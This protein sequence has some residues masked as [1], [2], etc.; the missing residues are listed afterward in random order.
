MES[1]LEVEEGADRQLQQAHGERWC[2][3]PS[4]ELNFEAAEELTSLREKLLAANEADASLRA[5]FGAQHDTLTPLWIPLELLREQVPQGAPLSEMPC[6]KDVVAL[7]E[8]LKT[9]SRS[10]DAL[11]AEARAH[12][13]ADD[14]TSALVARAEGESSDAIF[15]AALAGY[16]PYAERLHD[17]LSQQVRDHGS[18]L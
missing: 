11:V 1:L 8:S 9:L 18:L 4:A 6:T 3:L 17:V 12:A 2:A 14:V 16:A 5:A 13:D 7:L 10:S 15:A